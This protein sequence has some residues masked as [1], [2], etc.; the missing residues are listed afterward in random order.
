MI[1]SKFLQL[2]FKKNNLKSLSVMA[3]TISGSLIAVFCQKIIIEHYGANALEMYILVFSWYILLSTLIKFGNEK[4]YI[5]LR[6]DNNFLDYVFLSSI[7]GIIISCIS[8][9]VLYNF[10][11]ITLDPKYL[12]FF[13]PSIVLFFLF[14]S[15]LQFIS[16]FLIA[17]KRPVLGILSNF[18][19]APLSF[20]FI[21]NGYFS[22]IFDNFIVAYIISIFII[23]PFLLNVIFHSNYSLTFS[24]IFVRFKEIFLTHYVFFFSDIVNVVANKASIFFLAYYAKDFQNMVEFSIAFAFLKVSMMG[25]N[26]IATVFSPQIS[27]SIKSN[28]LKLHSVFSEVRLLFIFI[29]IISFF[30]IFTL[31]D[32]L[33]NYFYKDNYPLAFELLLILQVGQI[34]HSSFGP[35]SQIGYFSGRALKVS[36]YKLLTTCLMILINFIFY[37]TLGIWILAYSYVFSIIVWNCLIYFDVKPLFK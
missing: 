27:D 8:G 11:S 26:S 33:I 4:I 35:I 5:V 15:I 6:G 32:T 7:I 25:I 17:N 22:N 13:K 14:P 23:I 24:N 31:G 3:L 18:I 20:I 29:S 19:S 2:F 16:I 21:Y 1:K 9:F 30:T 37:D 36:S 12:E 10:F 28:E 34:I